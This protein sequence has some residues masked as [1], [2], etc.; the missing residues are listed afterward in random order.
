LLG[1]IPALWYHQVAFGAPWI[2]GYAFKATPEFQAIIDSGFHGVGW[3]TFEALWGVLGSFRRGLFNFSPLLLIACVGA[4]TITRRDGGRT[5]RPVLAALATYVLFAAGFV[6]W[7]AGWCAAARHLTPI[8]GLLVVLAL[9]AV[10]VLADHRLGIVVV[11][12]LAVSSTLNTVLTVALTPFFPP[13]FD[14]PLTQL[15][16]PSLA[17][18]F[19]APNIVS[20]VFGVPAVWVWAAAAT[21]AI[22]AVTWGVVICAPHRARWV[23]S[24]AALS[25]V[26][27]IAILTAQAFPTQPELE[28]FRSMTLDVL[29]HV[30]TDEPATSTF[31]VE[32]SD[33]TKTVD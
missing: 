19:A 18:G 22:C 9:P 21:I 28:G 14:R 7:T 32:P 30:E 13:E 29:G 17:D 16:V 6:D 20:A 33:A 4:W 3:P 23:V 11:T 5:V 26:L 12:V 15:V 2:T 25:A 27:Y 10:N 8:V 24:T 31:D 1:L